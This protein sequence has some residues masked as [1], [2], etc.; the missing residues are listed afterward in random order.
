MKILY[1]FQKTGNGHIA[2]A[3]E[4]IP[5]LQKIG[6][7]DLLTSGN[8]SQLD[9][10]FK[11]N[12]NFNGI[13][14]V[15]NKKGKVSYLKTLLQNNY[16]KFFKNVFQ[17]HVNSYDII[18]NDFEPVSAWASKL[19][20]GNCISLSHQASLLFENTPKPKKTDLISRLILK[21]YAPCK[22]KYGFHFKSYHPNLFPPVIRGKIKQLKPQ[23]SE[24]NFVVYLPAFSDE[25][26]IKTLSK[27]PVNWH[28]FSRYT[29]T[30]FY[31]NNCSVNPINEEDF[32]FK[33]NHCEG[34]LC[35]AGFELPAETLYLN[36]KLLVIPIKKQLEQEYN[37]LALKKLG[38]LTLEKL[39]T[40]LIDLWTRSQILID[41]EVAK[42]LEEILKSLIEKHGIST[43]PMQNYQLA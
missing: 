36:K 8:Q 37:A 35:H 23:S 4:I 22:I 43:T 15:Y 24:G 7:V 2:R 6:T 10:P 9:I 33:L 14:L 27:I 32:L 25:K 30:E 40:N 11:I 28:I 1:A 21:L 39:D 31:V 17:L 20:G 42:D 26:I 18:I 29:S 41:L 3:Q 38:V 19:K 34:V 12:Y 13:S 16:W 5:I